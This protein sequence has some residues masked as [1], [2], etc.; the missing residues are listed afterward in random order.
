MAKKSK[1]MVLYEVIRQNQARA[2]GGETQQVRSKKREKKLETPQND[3]IAFGS[4]RQRPGNHWPPRAPG[5]KN[6]L[7]RSQLARKLRII[8][9][10]ARLK[11]LLIVIMVMIIG[12]KSIQ[13]FIGTPEI[14]ETTVEQVE[15]PPDVAEVAE[16]AA[17]APQVADEQKELIDQTQVLAPIGDHTIVIMTYVEKKDLAPAKD[18]FEENGIETRIEKRG[19]YYFLLTVD[20]FMSPKRSGTDGYNALKKIKQ[21]GAE[22]KA[23]P[24]FETFGEKP[25]QD[26]YGMKIR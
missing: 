22:Y 2:K 12:V 25:F 19:S 4:P 1:G 24:G 20:R 16:I 17:E 6:A 15:G 23:P 26:A 18:F 11:A 3:E 9:D 7:L 5:L 10:P 21:I 13:F 8:I 14:V